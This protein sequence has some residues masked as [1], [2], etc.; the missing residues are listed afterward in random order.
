V[1]V[2]VTVDMS[3]VGAKLD[4]IAKDRGLGMFLATEAASGMEQY[5]PYR[6]GYLSKS[7]IPAPFSVSYG[8]PYARKMY[9]GT[10]FHFSD[11]GHAKATAEWDKAYVRAKGGDLGR[12][13]TQYVRGM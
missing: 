10:D 8:M 3:G 1:A 7:A 13:G 2:K 4:S 5:V 12:A 11:Q 9:Y 6:D